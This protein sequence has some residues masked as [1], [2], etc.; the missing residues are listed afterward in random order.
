M[1]R[2]ARRT[3]SRALTVAVLTV[4]VLAAVTG[5]VRSAGVGGAASDAERA[6]AV[7][8]SLRCPTCQ[9]LSVADSGSPLAKSMRQIIDE[10]VAAGESEDEVRAYFVRRYGDWV[11]LTPRADGSG[12]LVWAL[13]VAA[14][15]AGLFAV[16]KLVRRRREETRL[17]GSPALRW[18]LVGGALVSALAVLLSLNLDGRGEGELATGN[19][20][21]LG[22]Q[23]PVEGEPGDG[24]AAEDGGAETVSGADLQQLEAAV[25]Q[26]PDDVRLR[27]ALASTAFEGGRL[28]VV[29][30]QAQEV[31]AREPDNVDALML[32]GLARASAGDRE[33]DA[34]LHRFLELAPSGHPAVP[35]VE[36]L[37]GGGR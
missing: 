10:Q 7:A 21:P 26:S 34:A 32:R 6:Q 29:R 2:R 15:V 11:L 33:A 9:G 14:V 25:G 37:L 27:L 3:S 28:D 24:A 16:A 22:A 1:D 18:V 12:L 8:E 35:L 31:L 17:A 5:L 20:T 13:P 36:E 30:A 19:V 4:L 23:A